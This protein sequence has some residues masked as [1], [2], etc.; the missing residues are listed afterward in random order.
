MNMNSIGKYDVCSMMYDYENTCSIL[1][2]AHRVPSVPSELRRAR[3]TSNQRSEYKTSRL[4]AAVVNCFLL[5]RQ[6]V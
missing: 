4:D 2:S 1:D 3:F 5:R 6:E